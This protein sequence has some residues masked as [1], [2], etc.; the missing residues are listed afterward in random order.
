MTPKKQQQEATEAVASS[1]GEDT[2]GLHDFIYDGGPT[3]LVAKHQW[4]YS[5]ITLSRDE[6]PGLYDRFAGWLNNRGILGPWRL[7]YRNNKRRFFK[8]Y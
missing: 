4:N 5:S 2:L 6:H 3:P 8:V 7:G 1:S